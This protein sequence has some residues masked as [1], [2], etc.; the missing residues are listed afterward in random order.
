[1]FYIINFTK[2]KEVGIIYRK[3]KTCSGL[4]AQQFNLNHSKFEN[5]Y[6]FSNLSCSDEREPEY[7]KITSIK[8]DESKT[9]PDNNNEYIESKNDKDLK[10]I[11]NTFTLPINDMYDYK[12]LLSP[13]HEKNQ[14]NRVVIIAPSGSGKSTFA[15]NYIDIYKKKFRKNDVFLFSRHECDPS[16]DAAKPQ[17]IKVTE[18]DIITAMK[19]KEAV[20]ENEQMANSLVIFDDIDNASSKILTNYWY[21]L[22]SDLAQNARKLSIDLMF[23]LHNTGGMK[24]R[25]LMSEATHYVF[26]LH[27]GSKA[28]YTRLITCYLGIKNTKTIKKLFN[29]PSRYVIICNVAPLYIMTETDIILLNDFE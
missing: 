28:M 1:M 20:I 10:I 7:K 17:R 3:Q 24:T 25:L 11:N 12:L 14:N 22:A 27:S 8:V 2:G 19:N 13:E 9:K 4:N 26:F 6:A 15:A 29:I 18:D 16:I 23:I 21:S 5:C